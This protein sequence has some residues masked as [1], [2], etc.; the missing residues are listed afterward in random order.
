MKKFKDILIASFMLDDWQ[1]CLEE[2]KRK[3]TGNTEQSL[4]GIY[5]SLLE[6]TEK[7]TSLFSDNDAAKVFAAAFTERHKMLR[8]QLAQCIL[9]ICDMASNS[10]KVFLAEFISE[11]LLTWT[12]AGKSFDE[13]YSVLNLLL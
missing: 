6:F 8:D 13:I 2:M 3:T 7:H 5:T 4:K 11:S 10:N 12:M 9:P 1:E